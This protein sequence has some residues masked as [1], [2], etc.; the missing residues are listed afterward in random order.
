MSSHAE[1]VAEVAAEH[2]ALKPFAPENGK[3]LRFQIGDAVI[4]TNDA[5]LEF[6]CRVSGL[7]RPAEPSGLYAQGARYLVDS[8]A[9]WMPVSEASLRS[10]ISVAR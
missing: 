2:D 7:Y 10:D 5:G 4:F 1:W 6:R 3:P 9:P 8:S